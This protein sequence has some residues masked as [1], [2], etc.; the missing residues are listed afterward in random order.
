M[1]GVLGYFFYLILTH[2]LRQVLLSLFCKWDE[3]L[4]LQLPNRARPNSK[5]HIVSLAPPQ[6]RMCR[7]A[8]QPTCLSMTLHRKTSWGSSL[9]C[10]TLW[11]DR[12]KFGSRRTQRDKYCARIRPK[13]QKNFLLP[14]A[15]VI[16]GLAII[17]VCPKASSPSCQGLYS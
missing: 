15:N 11:K 2:L 9:W 8:S 4:T 13:Q 12:G 16:F 3:H 7:E 10:T 17:F 6:E 1:F 5:A 14:S